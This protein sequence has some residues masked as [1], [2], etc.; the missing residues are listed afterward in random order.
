MY[1]IG[2][3]VNELATKCP[4]CGS[5]IASSAKKCPE[6]GKTLVSE[7]FEDIGINKTVNWYLIFSKIVIVLSV[8]AAGVLIVWGIADEYVIWLIPCGIVALGWGILYSKEAQWK[9]Y[10]LKSTHEIN[11]KMNK[12]D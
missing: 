5:N 8:I 12:K 7:S 4:N 2:I 1:V 9:A 6:C 11:K 3:V 10:M